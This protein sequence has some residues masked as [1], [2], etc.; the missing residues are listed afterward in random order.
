MGQ[1]K[2]QNQVLILNLSCNSLGQNSL[3]PILTFST[4]NY[5]LLK[6]SNNKRHALGA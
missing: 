1:I 4:V 5:E 6:P 3:R 2:N